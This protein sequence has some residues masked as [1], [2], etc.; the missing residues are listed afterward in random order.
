[1]PPC[2]T[3]NFFGGSSTTYDQSNFQENCDNLADDRNLNVLDVN[4][5]LTRAEEQS[6]INPTVIEL[7]DNHD[8]QDDVG[9][10]YSSE[11]ET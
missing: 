1:V 6:N 10:Y 8:E 5:S 3:Y 4:L 9:L 2:H 7:S 11:V